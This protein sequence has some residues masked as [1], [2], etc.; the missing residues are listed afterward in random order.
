[1]FIS[2]QRKNLY[3]HPSDSLSIPSRSKMFLVQGKGPRWKPGPPFLGR[4]EFCCCWLR[5]AGKYGANMAD[6]CCDWWLGGQLSGHDV[7]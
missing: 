7:G 5:E 6:F 3:Q 2:S 4:V 1:M